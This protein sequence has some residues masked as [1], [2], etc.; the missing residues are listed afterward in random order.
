MHPGFRPARVAVTLPRMSKTRLVS[1]PLMVRLAAPGPSMSR[2]FLIASSSLVRAMV[3]PLRPG[4]K[5]I[6]SPS[7]AWPI[8][9]RREPAPLS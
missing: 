6:V 5:A 2:L 1:L 4:A 9:S 8:A 3:W 7:W